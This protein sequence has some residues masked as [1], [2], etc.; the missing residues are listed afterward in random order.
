LIA[1]E[2][3]RPARSW[4]GNPAR[5]EELQL[6]FFAREALVFVNLANESRVF[7]DIIDGAFTAGRARKWIPQCD[8]FPLRGLQTRTSSEIL[9]KLGR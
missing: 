3:G 2:G 6:L 7:F 8:P 5:Q 1:Q 4:I 9:D